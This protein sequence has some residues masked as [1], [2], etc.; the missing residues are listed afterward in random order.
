[1]PA[2]SLKEPD[3]ALSVA[4]PLHGPDG[5]GT[6]TGT[7]TAMATGTGA[8]EGT[9]GAAGG[10]LGVTITV[11]AAGTDGGRFTTTELLILYEAVNPA[12]STELS[13]VNTTYMFPLVADTGPG[14]DPPLAESS[15]MPD[16]ELPSYTFTKS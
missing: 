8:G 12:F 9:R 15:S 10:G 13:D 4:L 5:A 7:G 16:A 14:F 6:G 11:E 1:M 3:E 2:P